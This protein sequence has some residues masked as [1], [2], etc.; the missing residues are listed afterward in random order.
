V[1][2][3]R[4]GLRRSA[5]AAA[6]PNSGDDID[7]DAGAYQNGGREHQLQHLADLVLRAGAGNSAATLIQR[8]EG[9][10]AAAWKKMS[11]N[12]GVFWL[13]GARSTLARRFSQTATDAC[14]PLKVLSCTFVHI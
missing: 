12:P 5:G 8:T 13:M 14:P 6:G 4:G 1:K 11:A 2:R 3:S 10:I 9:A 7:E